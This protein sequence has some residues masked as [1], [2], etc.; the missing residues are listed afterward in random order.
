[1]NQNFIILVLIEDEGIQLNDNFKFPPTQVIGNQIIN[2]VRDRPQTAKVKAKHNISGV[3]NYQPGMDNNGLQF[4]GSAY[5]YNPGGNQGNSYN[6]PTDALNMIRNYSGKMKAKRPMSASIVGRSGR[7]GQEHIIGNTLT[8][9]NSKLPTEYSRIDIKR[10]KPKRITQEKEKLYEQ[11]LKFKIQMN[12]F[13]E[14]NTRL[15]TRLRFLEKEQNEKEGII[16]DLANNN[17]I[18]TI[19]RLGSVYNKKKTDSY[20][21]TALKRQI[22][23]LRT[24]LKEKDD[25]IA[26]FKKN[27]RNTK[28]TELDIELR[29]YMDECLRLRHLLEDTIKS[30]DPLIDP[31]QA[32]QIEEQFNQQNVIIE[33]MQVENQ[34]LT[35]VL[36]Q[37]ENETHEWRNLVEEYQKRLNKL[38][39]AAK[40]N[41][42]LRKMNK[43][44][45]L[46]LT[47]IRQELLLLRSK[48]SPEVKAKVDEMIRKQDDLAGKVGTN[49]AKITVLK[50]EKNKLQDQKKELMDKIDI[51]ETEKEQIQQELEEEHN[52]KK[53]FEELYGEER[54]KNLALRDHLEEITKEDKSHIPRNQSAR[55]RSASKYGRKNDSN[56]VTGNEEKKDVQGTQDDFGSNASA[57]KEIL[58][59]KLIFSDVE[60]IAAELR[61]TFQIMNIAYNDIISILP[62]SSLT[63]NNLRDMLSQKYHIED[64]DAL[65]AARYI[66]EEDDDDESKVLF[67]E[68]K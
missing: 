1:M 17:E 67:D 23:D 38:R 52:L 7:N 8:A 65:L 22:K 20:L 50:K 4:P 64:N 53:K 15:R 46:E 34:E 28:I 35:Q 26:S 68:E 2:N 44:K 30:K 51:L 6:Y 49:K 47:K 36:N 60:S 29:S 63:L 19:G 57:E 62:S 5:Q 43:D 56:N 37:K 61:K 10:M 42:K 54:E 27:F 39:P 33:N 13:K 55:P 16:E 59:N 66:F 58:V 48:T 14:E 32:N 41:K 12:N 24:A 9:Q 11:S 21:T 40:E 18:T 45:K 31:D 3:K 25:E